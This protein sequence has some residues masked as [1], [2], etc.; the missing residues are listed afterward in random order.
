M[1]AQE[2]LDG[3]IHKSGKTGHLFYNLFWGIGRCDIQEYWLISWAIEIIRENQ[4]E[5]LYNNSVLFDSL[6]S[7]IDIQEYRPVLQEIANILKMACHID[8]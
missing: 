6:F 2:R 4:I 7:G 5:D 8:D 3:T 1:A